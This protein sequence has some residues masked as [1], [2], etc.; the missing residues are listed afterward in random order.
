MPSTPLPTKYEVTKQEE[1]QMPEAG[2]NAV[3]PPGRPLGLSAGNIASESGPDTSLSFAS[4]PAKPEKAEVPKLE[5]AAPDQ[6]GRHW[7]FLMLAL[8]PDP[9]QAY[10][11]NLQ[12]NRPSLR[13]L[14]KPTSQWSVLA[15]PLR[16]HCPPSRQ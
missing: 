16:S 3:E 14:V 4:G 8:L 7:V 11:C 2:P 12:V 13:K 5:S 9:S 10:Y 15:S 1:A 6:S